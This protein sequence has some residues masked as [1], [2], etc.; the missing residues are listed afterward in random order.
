MML[1]ITLTATRF[2]CNTGHVCNYNVNVMEWMRGLPAILRDKKWFLIKRRR[3]VRAGAT[4]TR[5]KPTTA[6]RYRLEAAIREALRH[7][8]KVY[9]GSAPLPNEISKFPYDGEQ[10]MFEQEECVDLNDEVHMAK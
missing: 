2:L 3:G 10:D 6:N 7:M 1:V 4:D 5:K 8:P 9:E